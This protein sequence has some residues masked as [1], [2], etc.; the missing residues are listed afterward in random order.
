VSGSATY[1]DE[2]AALGAVL[3]ELSGEKSFNHV[4]D[5][6]ERAQALTRRA[7]GESSRQ[8]RNS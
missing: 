6:R 8:I 4:V 3:V 1:V 5:A 7:A 2:L